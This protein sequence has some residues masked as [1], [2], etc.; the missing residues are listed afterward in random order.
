MSGESARVYTKEGAS[1][2]TPTGTKLYAI[3]SLPM[4]EQAMLESLRQ[5]MEDRY[6]D[7]R[8]DVRYRELV[9]GW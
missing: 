5:A 4:I 8:L 3:R 9:G 1:R 2:L 6:I 7:E